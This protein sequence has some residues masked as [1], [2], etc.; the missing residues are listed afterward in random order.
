MTTNKNMVI[1]ANAGKK[2]VNVI[3]NGSAGALDMSGNGLKF[4]SDLIKGD[5]KIKIKVINRQEI[6]L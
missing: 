3:K 4:L 2:A 5:K 6:V 1:I